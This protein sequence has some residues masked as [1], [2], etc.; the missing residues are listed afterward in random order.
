MATIMASH[1]LGGYTARG[2]LVL[3]DA[4]KDYFTMTTSRTKKRLPAK[5]VPWADAKRKHRLSDTQIQMARELGMNPKKLGK[6]D[7]H[8][9]EPWKVPL[10]AFIEATYR[11]RFKRDRPEQVTPIPTM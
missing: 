8:K 3:T 5:L 10:P 11:R 1:L 2:L 9:Q 4:C 7:N 6:L